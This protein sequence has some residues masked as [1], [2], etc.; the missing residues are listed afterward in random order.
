MPS[1]RTEA[2]TASAARV[3]QSKRTI[4]PSLARRP[5]ADHRPPRYGRVMRVVEHVHRAQVTEIVDFRPQFECKRRQTAETAWKFPARTPT[6]R[7]MR[8]PRYLHN[9]IFERV[10]RHPADAN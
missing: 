6:S 1:A 9:L 7:G 10:R 3:Q 2:T 5:P 8:V 4:G